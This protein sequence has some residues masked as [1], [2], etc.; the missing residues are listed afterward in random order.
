MGKIL[1]HLFSQ[2]EG[3]LKYARNLAQKESGVNDN[4]I[5]RLVFECYSNVR[6]IDISELVALDET[7]KRI[8][9]DEFC[10]SL[11]NQIYNLSMKL[12]SKYFSHSTYQPQGNKGGFQFEV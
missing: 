7:G 2:L 4:E 11:Q 10:N 6:L 3:L 9:L 12:N 1:L 8:K 5:S